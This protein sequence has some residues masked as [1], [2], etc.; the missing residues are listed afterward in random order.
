MEKSSIG[1]FPKDFIWGAATAAFQIEGSTLADG[2]GESVW[3]RFAKSPGKI[4]GGHTGEP[5]CDHYRRWREDI[6]L[7]VGLGLQAYR[8]SVAWPRVIPGGR[9]QVNEAGLDFYDKLVDRLLEKN[10]EPY[11]TLYHWDLPQVLQ[12]EGGWLARSTVDAFEGYAR[13]V[14]Q[15]LGDR[16]RHW[17][18]MN[19]IPCFIGQ[20]YGVGAHHAPGLQVPK[21][22]VNQGYHHAFLAHGR[23]VRLVR[24]W[25]RPDSEVG[26][27]NN[28]FIPV[29]V[30]ESPANDAAAQK[31]FEHMNS[32][33]VDPIF[34]GAYASWW[35]AEQ[36][37][38][39]PDIQDGDMQVI[40]S[41]C[42]F[43]GI[44]AYSGIFVEAADNAVGYKALKFPKGYTKLDLHW[45]K[46]VPQVLYWACRHLKGAY[47]VD[48][49][50]ISE[51]G[52]ACDDELDADG[53][54]VDLDR[55][56]W[57]RN[58]LRQAQ[59]A[60]AEGLGL[61][62]YFLWSLMDNFEWAEGYLKR[63]GIV[64]ID[65]ATQARVLKESGKWYQGVIREQTG[66]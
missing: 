48:K 47:G 45:L 55:L 7:M 64:H 11:L 40:S 39:V 63:F 32:Y 26:L 20:S 13:V 6:D 59:R 60:T 54:V 57:L 34:R 29:P 43:H 15:R 33:L 3:D 38:D 24:E 21:K 61:S 44:N 49:T 58:H 4:N 2:R 1:I 28:P 18:T 14:I 56:E 5:A 51:N 52:C 46:P 66:S 31:A 36:G 30:S 12:D 17:M 23:A 22:Q 42:D 8:F 41:P 35:L 19:E 27:V 10:I 65:Y 53:R 9:G 62:G 37:A 50:Y 25:A 16:V